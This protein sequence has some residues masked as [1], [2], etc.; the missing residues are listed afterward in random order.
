MP[1]VAKKGGIKVWHFAHHTRGTFS[2]AR[3]ECLHSFFVSVRMMA[4]QVLGAEANLR[5]PGLGYVARGFDRHGQQ[6]LVHRDVALERVVTLN[7]IQVE[8]AFHGAEV[9]FLGTVSGTE[10]ALY[11]THPGR[12]SPELRMEGSVAGVL[13]LALDELPARFGAERRKELPYRELLRQFLLDDV[14]SKRWL[15]HPRF[16]STRDEAESALKAMGGNV[17]RIRELDQVPT[18][19]S[20]THQVPAA[21]PEAFLC[22]VCGSQWRASDSA[23]NCPKC[24]THLYSKAID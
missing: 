9:D 21:R 12:V 23:D 10:L 6:I 19:L 20:V 14:R 7:A 17:T 18:Q 15:Y 4:R 13:T 16:A 8:V 5:V 1:L 22:V 2:D 3:S 24:K 11:L